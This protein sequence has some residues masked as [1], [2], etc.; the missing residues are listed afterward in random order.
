MLELPTGTV[1]LRFPCFLG[2]SGSGWELGLD[3]SKLQAPHFEY[4]WIQAHSLPKV[5]LRR[6]MLSISGLNLLT[7]DL[8]KNDGFTIGH[9]GLSPSGCKVG[10]TPVGL[11]KWFPA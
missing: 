3:G 9:S 2:P 7:N 8:N 6:L 11:A 10:N 1:R 4:F 5:V